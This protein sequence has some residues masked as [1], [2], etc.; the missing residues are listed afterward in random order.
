MTFSTDHFFFGARLI[1]ALSIATLVPLL[2]DR[3]QRR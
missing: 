2:F 1:A 3:R